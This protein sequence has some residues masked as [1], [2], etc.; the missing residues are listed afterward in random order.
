[1]LK[2]LSIK[3]HHFKNLKEIDLNFPDSG[4]ILIMGKNES[5]KSTLF[6][7]VYFAL[8]GELLVKGNNKK[9][10]KDAVYYSEN[11]A[12]VILTFTKGGKKAKIERAI[13]LRYQDNGR[14]TSSQS[15]TFWMNFGEPDEIKYDSSTKEYRIEDVKQ[16]IQ[17]FVG[18]DGDI[19]ENSCFVKQKGLDGFIETSLDKKQQIINKLLNLEKL[20]ILKKKY[21]DEISVLKK[22]KSY[23]ED[24]DLIESGKRK[25]NEC[26]NIIK[27]FDDKKR[28]G[29]R[30]EWLLSNIN[31][32]NFIELK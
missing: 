7:A 20:S 22:V 17:D 5:G 12:Y 30:Y 15:V 9:S 3:V 18:F 23:L 21:I 19:L 31:N 32:I 16:K 25:I 11:Y 1:M 26:E 28:L 2:L 6:E 14:V 10:Y 27:E 13:N 29:S 8:T 4:N 24:R